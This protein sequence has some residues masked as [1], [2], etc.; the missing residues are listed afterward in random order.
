MVDCPVCSWKTLRKRTH[1]TRVWYECT[2]CDT[3]ITNTTFESFVKVRSTDNDEIKRRLIE[4]G[5][6]NDDLT[7]TAAYGGKD[8][9]S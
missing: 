2:H 5:I 9:P 1:L 4:S 6:Y 8:V 7:L 3:Q